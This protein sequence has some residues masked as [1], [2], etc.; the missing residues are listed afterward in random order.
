MSQQFPNLDSLDFLFVWFLKDSGTS[1]WHL[2]FTRLTSRARQVSLRDSYA[3]STRSCLAPAH[4]KSG[5]HRSH[6][7]PQT[8]KTNQQLKQQ[9]PVE[10]LVKKSLHRSESRELASALRSWHL[11]S[12]HYPN[13]CFLPRF[14]IS[15]LATAS[16]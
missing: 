12:V 3:Q 13:T 5:Y 16:S 15:T 14:Q 11:Y 7:K 2:R 9:K 1:C 4:P 6:Q 10:I 8:K